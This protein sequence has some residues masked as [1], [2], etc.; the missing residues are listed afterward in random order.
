MELV[1]SPVIAAALTLF[2]LM[3][4]QVTVRRSSEMAKSARSSTLATAL[5]GIS[6]FLE[7]Q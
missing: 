1:Y 2:K 6:V 4:W 5:F 7:F 3:G